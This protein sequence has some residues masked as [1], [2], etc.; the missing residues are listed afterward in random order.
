[1]PDTRAKF[2]GTWKRVTDSPCSQVYPT[3]IVFIPTGS[4]SASGGQPGP[5]PG[6][7]AGTWVLAGPNKIRI[8]TANDSIIV[9]TFIFSNDELLFIDPTGCNF[10][11][12]RGE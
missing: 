6:W 10:K 2:I 11:Y 12:N 4:Y 9:Y 5:V 3:K 7:D 8:S 1:M